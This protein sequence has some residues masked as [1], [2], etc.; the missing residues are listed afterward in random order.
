MDIEFFDPLINIKEE[1]EKQQDLPQPPPILSETV[2]VAN[3]AVFNSAEPHSF[4]GSD[5]VI[6]QIIQGIYAAA[7][8]NRKVKK[9]VSINKPRKKKRKMDYNEDGDSSSDE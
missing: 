7:K 5:D 3:S 9:S 1:Q 4:T 6:S 8:Y 2:K